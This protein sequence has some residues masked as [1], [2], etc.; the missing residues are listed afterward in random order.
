VG[1]RRAEIEALQGVEPID[2]LAIYL[3]AFAPKKHVDAR[4]PVSHAD[5][6]IL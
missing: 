4:I 5:V 2:A 1:H 6:P 3:E